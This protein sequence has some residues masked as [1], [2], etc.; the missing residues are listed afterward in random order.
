MKK[1]TQLT[2]VKQ[3][4]PWS[5]E[6][7]G[8]ITRTVAK[9]ASMDELGLFFNI[10]K[11]AKLDPFLR[12][13]HLIPR[14]DKDGNIVRTPQVG[15]DGYLA[16]AERTGQLAGIDDAI[17]EVDKNKDGVEA[18]NPN[19][20]TVTVY[21]MVSGQRVPFTASARWKEYYPGEKLG[22][23]WNKM[24]FNQ[25]SKCAL[26]L[27]LRRAFP[28]D[29]GG[30]YVEEEMGRAGEVI[31]VVVEEK[32]KPKKTEKIDAKPVYYCQGCD[33]EISK[34]DQE[35]SKKLSNDG[36]SYC[37]NCLREHRK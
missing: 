19:K 8:L 17:F 25:L 26:A 30:M 22:F 27:A 7:I 31:D 34:A 36:K 21:R 33:V 37:A 12:Q 3:T 18:K 14:R 29:L 20:A 28:T 35:L 13:I 9:G 5:K 16:I 32:P 23:M 6:Q 15:I 10:A 24:P 2:E 11:R 4:S 1:T